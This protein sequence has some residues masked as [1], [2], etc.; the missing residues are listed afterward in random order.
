MAK[1]TNVRVQKGAP[2][3]DTVTAADIIGKASVDS[4]SGQVI[5]D[6]SNSPDLKEFFDALMDSRPIA[7]AISFQGIKAESKEDLDG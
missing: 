2:F 6:L 5:L 3:P 7:I 1:W 4:A